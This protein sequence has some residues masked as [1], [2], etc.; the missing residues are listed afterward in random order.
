M[1]VTL[2]PVE[3]VVDAWPLALPFMERA[4]EYTYGRY[5][6]DDILVSIL[7]Y[8]H[9]LWLAFEEDRT[10]KG[11]VVTHFKRYPRKRY[12]DMTFIGGDEAL[13]WKDPMLD[14]L[15]RW[16][17]DNHCDGIES[18]GRLGWSRALK[19]DGYTMLWQVYELPIATSG[20]EI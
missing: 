5:T 20:L 2:V 14:I 11:A 7:R 4:A 15:R 19:D 9:H 10:V 13:T 12:L 17:T 16:A 1:Q 3:H 8:D 6:A 18:A